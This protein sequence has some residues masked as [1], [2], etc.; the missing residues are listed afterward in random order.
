[1]TKIELDKIIDNT[2]PDEII[3]AITKKKFTV[4]LHLEAEKVTSDG[5]A[6][7][8][9]LKKADFII[10]LGVNAATNSVISCHGQGGS[11]AMDDPSMTCVSMGGTYD[12][13]A[14]PKCKLPFS[15]AQLEAICLIFQGGTWNS[16]LKKCNLTPVNC[17]GSFSSCS[18][19]CGGGTQTYTVTQAASAGGV[20]CPFTTGYV[21]TC[22]T[23]ACATN[24]NCVGSWGSCSV[25]CGG[26]IQTFS[27]S[28]PASGSGTACSYAAGAS[29]TCNTSACSGSQ[30]WSTPGT[31]T[32][33]VPAGVTSVQVKIRG[34]GGGGG[35]AGECWPAGTMGPTGAGV[36]CPAHYACHGPFLCGGGSGCSGGYVSQFVAVVPLNSI[37]VIVGSGGA[38]GL[39]ATTWNGNSSSGS[40]GSFS[41]FNGSIV[42]AGGGG[43]F[44]TVYSSSSAGLGCSSPP[45]GG[46]AGGEGTK[47]WLTSGGSS[48]GTFAAP[49]G[50]YGGSSGWWAPYGTASNNGS[51]GG[52]GLVE[53]SW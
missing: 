1:M 14:T 24:V 44:G 22:N 16:I 3:G 49:N 47:G 20:A 41:S 33:V 39:S 28:T 34:G 37:Q 9:S 38:P 30:T 36:G 12:A 13:M 31:Y 10:F 2:E 46:T 23:A 45:T 35:G 19:A 32:F 53:V 4:N 51:N 40:A 25:P 6:V 26:G 11:S 29:R 15:N 5:P 52:S 27:I 17:I 48:G 42:A 18:A 50:G 8:G 7:G 21:Q 43:G